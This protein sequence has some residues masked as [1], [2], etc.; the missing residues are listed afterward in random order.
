MNTQKRY[1]V[2][3]WTGTADFYSDREQQSWWANFTHSWWPKRADGNTIDDELKQYN[4]YD[5]YQTEYIEFDT[6][7]DFLVFKLKFS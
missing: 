7:A 5:V 2:C 4:G 1:R 6:E 3:V